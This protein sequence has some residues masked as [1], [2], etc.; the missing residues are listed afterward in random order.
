MRKSIAVL[1]SIVTLTFGAPMVGI[2]QAPPSTVSGQVVDPGG[3]G[4]AGS[5]LELVSDSLVVATTISTTD[6]HFSFPGVPLG[7]Y[8]VRTY[9]NGQP[10]G[11]RVAVTAGSAASALLVL[12]SVANASPAVIAVAAASA[13]GPLVA[14]TVMAVGS[15]V[16]ISEEDDTETVISNQQ[17]ALN[18]LGQL[19]QQNPG[20]VA[21][22]GYDA[23]IDLIQAIIDPPRDGGAGNGGDGGGPGGG[24]GGGDG[25]FQFPGFCNNPSCT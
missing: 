1:L 5:R 12:P 14:G 15:T 4:A 21:G 17:E 11:I 13:L 16:V 24:P 2:A 22:G 7:S 6:G 3:R 18:Y 25:G 8:V 20:I 19:V 10:I 9:V 23:L